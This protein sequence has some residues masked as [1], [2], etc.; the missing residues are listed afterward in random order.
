MV[1]GIDMTHQVLVH[2][3]GVTGREFLFC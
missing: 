2:P 3:E 1:A